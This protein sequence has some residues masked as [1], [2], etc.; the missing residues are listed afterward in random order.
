MA[1]LFSVMYFATAIPRLFYPYDLD[2]VEDGLLLTSLRLAAGQPVFLPPNADFVPHVYMPLYT[3]LGGLIFAV[4]GPSFS[5]LRLLSLTALLTSTGLVFW[6]TRRESGQNW[7]A[8]VCAGLLLGGYRL[9]GFWYEL[10]RV[11]TLFVALTLSGLTLATYAAPKKLGLAAAG[12]MLALAFLTK[13]TGLIFGLGA[14]IYLL[15]FIGRRAW[16]FGA[17]FGLLALL[18]LAG[19]NWLT[20]GWFWFY[21]FHIASVNPVEFERVVHYLGLELLGQM[22]GL[23]TLALAAAGLGFRR[24]G[25]RI[26]ALQPWLLWLGLAALVSGLG[27]ASIGGNL[28]NL[29]PVYT[30]LCLSPALLWREWA[31]RPNRFSR[32]QVG[33]ISALILLQFVSGVYN[34]LRYQPTPAM[35]QSGDHLIAALTATEGEV[36]VMM[37]PYYAWLA[38][39][40]P[41]AQIAALWY[42]RDRGALP[43]PEDLVTRLK[44]HYYALIISDNS[45][46]EA[47]PALQ[48][49]LDTYYQPAQTLGPDDAP[50]TLTGMVVRPAVMYVPKNTIKPPPEQR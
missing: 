32:W 6:I 23:S 15:T 14:F 20:Q 38:D 19:L 43:L 11:D 9:T 35:R 33:L 50:P 29:M 10:V 3:W 17:T 27:R 16:L 13:Q 49:L 18:P 45:L 21:T 39:K 7:L 28:N 24:A 2:F 12:G 44:G 30:L 8:L 25:W 41:S 36:L 4:T 5:S 40:T 42:T 34:P 31:S 47:E 48:Q 37:H 26:I 46:F 22:V 1:L